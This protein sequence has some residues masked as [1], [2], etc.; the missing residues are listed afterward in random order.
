M[1][2]QLHAHNATL[3]VVYAPQQAQAELISG[4]EGAGTD[5]YAL[6]AA[7]GEIARRHGAQFVDAAPQFRHVARVSDYYYPVDGHFNG[8]G[9][10]LLARLV[11]QGLTEGPHPVL[12]GCRPHSGAAN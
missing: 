12:A 6:S 5:P 10:A 11:T 4:Q 7:I 9:H 8:Q 3:L 2:D 1:A